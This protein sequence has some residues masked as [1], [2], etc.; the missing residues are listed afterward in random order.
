VLA[1]N[2]LAGNVL[3]GNV[4]TSKGTRIGIARRERSVVR[5][6]VFP[7]EE[8]PASAGWS[9][10]TCDG[11]VGWRAEQADNATALAKRA[12]ETNG[13]GDRVLTA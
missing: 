5:A 1:G 10:R 7:V 4:P 12:I 9:L 11:S 8:S 13:R 3:A 2:V 6:S